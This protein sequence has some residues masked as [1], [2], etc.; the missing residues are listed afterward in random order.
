[1]CVHTA[2]NKV[3]LISVVIVGQWEMIDKPS[4]RPWHGLWNV[5]EAILGSS[6]SSTHQ[7][8]RQSKSV[9]EKKP[10]NADCVCDDSIQ[11]QT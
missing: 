4:L 5:L 8:A 3:I 1:M 11:R 10:E 6:N 2:H 7:Q 9:L